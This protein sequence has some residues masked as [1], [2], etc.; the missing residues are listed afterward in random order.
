MKF[1]S[2]PQG[3]KLMMLA[4]QLPQKIQGAFEAQGKRFA[5]RFK[6]ATR[7]DLRD[8]KSAIRQLE[9]SLK[10]MESHANGKGA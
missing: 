8:L 6:L 2:T 4:F 5:K 10:Q 1:M 7:E 3:Q 9:Q